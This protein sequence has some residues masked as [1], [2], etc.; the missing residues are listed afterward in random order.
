MQLDEDTVQQKQYQLEGWKI[1]DNFT[2]Y[3]SENGTGDNIL[4][5]L[6]FEEWVVHTIF[7]SSDI[8]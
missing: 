5:D 3:L 8:S 6:L 1:T 7:P 4:L 2:I